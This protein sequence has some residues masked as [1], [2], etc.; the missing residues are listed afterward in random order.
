MGVG[1]ITAPTTPVLSLDEAKAHLR[2]A[3]ADDEQDDIVE[4]CVQAASDECENW[5]GRKFVDQVWKLVL[6]E[7]PADGDIII[8]FPPLIEVQSVGYYDTDGNLVALDAANYYV[9]TFSEPGWVV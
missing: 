1:I 9:D 4:A 7:F 5:T 3:S 8:P 6:D 2:I